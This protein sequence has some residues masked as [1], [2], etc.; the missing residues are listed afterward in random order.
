MNETYSEVAARL[1]LGA[2]SSVEILLGTGSSLSVGRNSSYISTFEQEMA[3]LFALA[4]QRLSLRVSLSLPTEH[5]S[6]VSSQP[7]INGATI[8]EDS[9]FSVVRNS[10]WQIAT[11]NSEAHKDYVIIDREIVIESNTNNISS[12]SH[13]IIHRTPDAVFS[14]C[15]FFDALWKASER[16][17]ILYENTFFLNTPRQDR[18][19]IFYVLNEE[20]QQ[21]IDRLALNP[22]A[23]YELTPRK[24]EELVAELL[25]KDGLTIQ[26]TPETRDGGKDII[27]EYESNLGKQLFLVECKRYSQQRP[28]SV[29]VIQR[30]YGLVEE[31]K[32][33]SGLVVTTSRF[34]RDALEYQGR[35]KHRMSL[36]KYEDI[37]SWLNKHMS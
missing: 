24:F 28:V 2:S 3:A 1:I 16:V 23:I 9:F 27:A 11:H 12:E 10:N 15:E 17:D 35:I 18:A 33:T 36:K 19:K 32:A 30:L 29:S 8:I 31:R 26:M 14:T 4:D 25:I 22:H 37:S 34:S 13:Y 7:Y 5:F 21:I 6:D 20:W